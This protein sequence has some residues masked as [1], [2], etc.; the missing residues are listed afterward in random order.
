RPTFADDAHLDGQVC[1]EAL[2]A[3]EAGTR[4]MRDHA[5]RICRSRRCPK[6]SLT[7]VRGRWGRIHASMQSDELAPLEPPVD[8]SLREAA[9]S[10]LATAHT[11]VLTGK[12]IGRW[13]R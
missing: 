11:A 1:I 13:L 8:A 12:S 2:A 7:G 9:G 3:V 6:G 4:P 10:Q 5:R